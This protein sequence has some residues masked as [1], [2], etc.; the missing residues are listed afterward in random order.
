MCKN[1][2]CIGLAFN[3]FFPGCRLLLS[4]LLCLLGFSKRFFQNIVKTP[5]ISLSRVSMYDAE[6]FFQKSVQL[7]FD[8]INSKGLHCKPFLHLQ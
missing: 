7:R 4:T 5:F 8:L 1:V 3:L 6:A 2:I